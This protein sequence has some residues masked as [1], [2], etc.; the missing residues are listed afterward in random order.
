ME[1]QNGVSRTI[2]RKRKF[3]ISEPGQVPLE[4][5]DFACPPRFFRFDLSGTQTHNSLL[6]QSSLQRRGAAS[7]VEFDRLARGGFLRARPIGT[8]NTRVHRRDLRCHGRISRNF[9]VSHDQYGEVG[10]ARLAGKL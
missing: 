10:P 3:W 2:S 6:V 8:R 1:I 7:V 4:V 9:C 5:V